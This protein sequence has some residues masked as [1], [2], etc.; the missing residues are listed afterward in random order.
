MNKELNVDGIKSCALCPAFVDTAMTEFAKESV[1]A[2]DMIRPED[3]AETVR[4]LLHVSPACVI[5][6]IMYQRPGEA[7]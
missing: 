3:I 7:L 5:P 4:A 2:E 1:S 6:E